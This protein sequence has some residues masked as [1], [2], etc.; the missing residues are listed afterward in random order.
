MSDA[1]V[2]VPTYNERENVDA[3]A[4]ALLGV[5]S[6]VDVLFVDDGSPDGTGALCDRLAAADARIHVLHRPRKQGLGRAY[7]AGFRWALERS[8]AFIFEMDADFSHDP[9]DVPVL[10]A[11]ASDGDLVLGSRFVGGIRIINWPM[12][13]LLLSKAAARFVRAVTGMPF[14][15]PTGGF[16]C[17]RREV[18]QTMPLDRITSNGYSFQIE[19]LHHAWM[20]GFRVKELPIIF[21]DRKHGTSKMSSAIIGEAF[22]LVWK[23]WL[24]AGLRRRPRPRQAGAGTTPEAQP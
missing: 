19:T 13:R 12:S 17:Y 1:L 24:R 16:K 11:A 9:K 10:L 18:I 6:R 7:V 22:W 8:Y 3:L 23:I 15:D 14:S 2:I 5:S 21:A 20:S 4:G